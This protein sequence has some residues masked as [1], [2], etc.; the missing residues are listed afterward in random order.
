MV[1]GILATLAFPFAF[2]IFWGPLA[3]IYVTRV[4]V[5]R[6]IKK[7]PVNQAAIRT[8]VAMATL[9]TP[10]GVTSEGG[11][12]AAIFPW[13]LAVIGDILS[14]TSVD[15]NIFSFY[16]A[17]P[18]VPAIWFYVRKRCKYIAAGNGNA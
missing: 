9:F 12:I 5:A 17:V 6:F 10:V 13:W 14:P 18:T 16:L 8:T 7:Y 2:Y 1:E 4:T 15:L 11:N 3:F